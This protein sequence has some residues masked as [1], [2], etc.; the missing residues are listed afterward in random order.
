MVVI[1]RTQISIHTLALRVTDAKKDIDKAMRYISI[2][3]L[4]LRVTPHDG[5]VVFDHR[6]FNPHP[7]TE[8][9]TLRLAYSALLSYFNPHPRTEGD[10]SFGGIKC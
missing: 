1:V 9:D 7:R 6:H 5:V 4:A 8:G 2:H 3:T 10:C